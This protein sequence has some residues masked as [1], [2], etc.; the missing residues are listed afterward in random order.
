[1]R[2]PNCDLPALVLDLHLNQQTEKKN[3]KSHT[4]KTLKTLTAS[5]FMILS[6]SAFAADGVKNE[7]SKI[8]NTLNTYVE[9]VANG[10]ME[11]L[12]DILDETMKFTVIRADKVVNYSKTD[13]LN[14]L[15]HSEN[16]VQNCTTDYEVEKIN[17]SQAIIKVIMKYEGFTKINYINLDKTGTGWKITNISSSYLK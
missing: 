14:Y 7:K 5:L 13:L 17:S 6:V 12:G 15:K 1:M 16:V 2:L 8:D 4:M 3:L 9:A 11:G 10:K